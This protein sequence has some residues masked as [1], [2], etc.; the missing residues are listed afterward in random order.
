VREVIAKHKADQT[1]IQRPKE[2][3]A[4]VEVEMKNLKVA[5]TSLKDNMQVVF[6]VK[7]WSTE[8]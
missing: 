4:I 1:A 3:K 7:L 6:F 5:Y 2:D 8:K